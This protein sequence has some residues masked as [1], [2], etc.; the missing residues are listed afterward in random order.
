MGRNCSLNSLRGEGNA[1]INGFKGSIR[2]AKSN[3]KKLTIVMH[4]ISAISI[5]LS[6]KQNNSYSKHPDNKN[7]QNH[8]IL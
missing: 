5:Q 7:K 1:R 8:A 6:R 4:T 3:R 2:Y